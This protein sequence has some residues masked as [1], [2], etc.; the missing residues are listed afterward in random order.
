MAIQLNGTSGVTTPGLDV[1][2]NKLYVDPVSGNVG[3]GNAAQDAFTSSTWK[4]LVIGSP[5]QGGAILLGPIET[6][7]PG[8]SYLWSNE[9]STFLASQVNG[10]LAIWHYNTQSVIIGTNDTERMRITADGNVGIGVIP[11]AW[12]SPY[13]TVQVSNASLTGGSADEAYLASNLYFN[14]SWKYIASSTASYYRQASGTHAWFTAASGTAGNTASPTERMRID[15]SGNVGIGTST[16]DP[17]VWEAGSRMLRMS[18]PDNYAVIQL[19]SNNTNKLWLSSGFSGENA[20]YVWTS[21]EQLKIGHNS[22]S[23]SVLTSSGR[24]E[25]STNAS[26]TSYPAFFARA[27]VNFNG[28]GTVAIRGSGNVSSIT[29]VGL[30]RYTVN[31]TTA[32]PDTDYCV[33]T[34][35]WDGN[36]PMSA[37]SRPLTTSTIDLEYYSGIVGSGGTQFDESNARLAVFR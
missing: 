13:K 2:T 24:F 16:I 15:S 3:I 4:S 20:S 19:D 37:Y 30:G 33:V 34:G 5:T 28:T 9:G 8:R 7:Y 25:S 12:E 29:D 31:L 6:G 11:S 26:A 32:M 17:S 35:G 21:G 23:F 22:C 27:W 36:A 14:G 10:P 18:S 1:T